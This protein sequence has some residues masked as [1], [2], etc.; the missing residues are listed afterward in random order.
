MISRTQELC[1]KLRPV[2]GRKIDGLWAAYLSE[3]DVGGKA[4][5]EQTLERLAAKHLGTDY[6]PDRSPFPPP[7]RGQAG[8]GDIPLGT[9]AYGKRTL[10][11]FR[12]QSGRLKEHLLVA[13][14]SGSGKTNL[15]FVLMQGILER[16]IQILALDWKRGYRDLLSL[17]PELRVYTIGRTVSPFRFNPL[18]PP[19]GC[20]PHV[21]IK[22]IVDVIASAYLGGEGVISLLVAGL[23][24]LFRETGVFD[25]TQMR[26][27]TVTDLLA[28]LR[29]VKLKGRAA[30]WQASAERILVAMTYGEFG[31]VINTQ[32]N[33][34]V[35]ELLKHNVVLE[36]DGLS[37]ASD[38]VM[39]SEAL[40]FP[41]RTR[42]L[43]FSQTGNARPGSVWTI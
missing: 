5:V 22:L 28:W 18:I 32:E 37:S 42:P 35:T 30:M 31:S 2:L 24:H 41:K 38:R 23:D 8:A 39:F 29:T 1:R 9:V 36:M 19:T 3:S 17:H 14:R 34:H 11:P 43:P 6:Q 13:G 4:D 21:W 33:S 7:L 12:L 40:R 16:G 15:T 27:P 26:W 25:Q 10:Y 20:E